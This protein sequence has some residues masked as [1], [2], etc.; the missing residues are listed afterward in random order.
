VTASVLRWMTYR[1]FCPEC[2]EMGARRDKESQ[3]KAD[4]KA[5]NRRAHANRTSDDSLTEEATDD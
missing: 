2:D 5:H 1:Y 4:A 3:A